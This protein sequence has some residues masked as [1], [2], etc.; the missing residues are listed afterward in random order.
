M[1]EGDCC[2]YV[3]IYLILIRMQVKLSYNHNS[4]Q[5]M[6]YIRNTQV[7]HQHLVLSG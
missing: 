1:Y 7:E 6:L 2:N 5:G 4:Q 3:N